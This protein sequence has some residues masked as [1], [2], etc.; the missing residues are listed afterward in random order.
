MTAP[1]QRVEQRVEALGGGGEARRLDAGAA[2]PVRLVALDHAGLAQAD[3]LAVDRDRGLALGVG[4]LVAE[5]L[6]LLAHEAVDGEGEQVGEAQL[7]VVDGH[8]VELLEAV[9]GLA[10][11]QLR[12]AVVDGGGVAAR[13]AA[14]EVLVVLEV[15]RADELLGAPTVLLQVESL[16]A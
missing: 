14:G 3:G 7:L 12:V 4:D 1:P 16:T 9:D 11:E 5:V 6:G 15:E 13:L 10:R 2:R 8:G